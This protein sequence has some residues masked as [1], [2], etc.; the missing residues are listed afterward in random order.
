[1]G[2]IWSRIFG[3]LGQN[4]ETRPA[5]YCKWEGFRWIGSVSFE[6]KIAGKFVFLWAEGKTTSMHRSGVKH[7]L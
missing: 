1:M 7:K 2:W 3:I 5:D 4:E 6:S